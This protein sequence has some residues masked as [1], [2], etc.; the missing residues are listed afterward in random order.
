MPRLTFRHAHTANERGYNPLT[1]WEFE[2]I[3]YQYTAGAIVKV[4]ASVTI[5]LNSF[6]Q[7]KSGS[8]VIQSMSPVTLDAVDGH[9]PNEEDVSAVVFRAGPGDQI[10][11]AFDEQVGG[12]A[13]VQGIVDVEP[14]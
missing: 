14:I 12:V 6:L 7:I 8:Q 13:I 4:M 10:G 1:G 9:L 5:A 3:P 2:K 11:L